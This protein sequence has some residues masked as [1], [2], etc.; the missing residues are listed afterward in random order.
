MVSQQAGESRRRKTEQ[1][2]TLSTARE[3]GQRKLSQRRD[4]STEVVRSQGP[5]LLGLGPWV[6]ELIEISRCVE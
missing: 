3:L 5:L 4:W 2:Y 1:R 6:D